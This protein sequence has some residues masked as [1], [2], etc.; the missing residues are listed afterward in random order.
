M[1]FWVWFAF[2]PFFSLFF[3]EAHEDP[4]F[5]Q[6]RAFGAMYINQLTFLQFLFAKWFFVLNAFNFVLLQR[7]LCFLSEIFLLLIEFD[8]QSAV[9]AG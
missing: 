2:L 5:F 8:R 6:Q 7:I 1:C 9:D 3:F 4:N